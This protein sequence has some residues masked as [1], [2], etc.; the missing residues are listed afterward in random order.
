MKN[1]EKRGFTSWQSYLDHGYT[2]STPRLKVSDTEANAIP[3]GLVMGYKLLETSTSPNVYLVQG[4]EK[5]I[6]LQQRFYFLGIQ[7]G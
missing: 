1:G 7:F 2:A 4:N 6:Y 5:E 3:T